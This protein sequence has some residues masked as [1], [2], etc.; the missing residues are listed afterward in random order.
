MKI[1]TWNVNSV[2]ARL[3]GIVDWLKMAAPDAVALQEIKTADE[4]FPKEAFEDLGYNCVV[5]GQKSYNGVAILSK[6]PPEDVVRG[7]DGDEQARYIEAVIPGETG[8]YRLASIYAPNGNPTE[9]ERFPYKLDW[10]AKLKMRAAELLTYEE[11]LILAGDFNVI[12]EDKDCYAPSAWAADAMY[13]PQSRAGL[14]RILNLGFCDAF[15]AHNNRPDQFTFWDYQAGSWD[16][17][18]GIRIDFLLLSPQA[19]DRLQTC[20]IDRDVRGGIKP[21]DHVPVWCELS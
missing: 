1:A 20:A 9:S 10:M 4:T 3:N 7:L 17:N 11:P 18:H 13:Q 12:P 6:R 14:S 21:S 15:R 16:K 5:Y 19:L 8:M 2:K